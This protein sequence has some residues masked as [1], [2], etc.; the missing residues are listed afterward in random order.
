MLDLP[1]FLSVVM[2]RLAGDLR[3]F[4]ALFAEIDA[5]LA[6]T[7]NNWGITRNAGLLALFQVYANQG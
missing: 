1:V 4:C 5:N 3:H 6:G 2:A 7:E